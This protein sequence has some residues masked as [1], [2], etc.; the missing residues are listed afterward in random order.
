MRRLLEKAIV[1]GRRLVRRKPKSERPAFKMTRKHSR[2]KFLAFSKEGKRLVREN[3]GLLGETSRLIEE[4]FGRLQRMEQVAGTEGL[5]IEPFKG[6]VPGNQNIMTLK[7][8]KNG[9]TFFV[10]ISRSD[11]YGTEGS[12]M[13]F[14]AERTVDRL[15]KGK[16]IFKGFKVKLVKPMIVYEDRLKVKVF[17]VTEFI[18]GDN[19]MHMWNLDKRKEHKPAIKAIFAARK[20]LA[21]HG[22]MD[23][24]PR[25]AFVDLESKKIYIFDP[26]KKLSA[27]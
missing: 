13:V 22:I 11:L 25:N 5:R 26:W 10:K 9:K 27:V 18:E 24:S 12:D 7:V 23:V 17:L 20:Y 8:S 3:R 19:I 16:S 4:N 1:A 14:T 21:K 6:A 2:R 15:R